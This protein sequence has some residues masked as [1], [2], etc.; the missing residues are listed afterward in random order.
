MECFPEH[1]HQLLTNR[2]FLFLDEVLGAVTRDRR[3][4]VVD[5]RGLA[6]ATYEP[7]AQRLVY[8]QPRRLVVNDARAAGVDLVEI[9]A[10]DADV[11]VVCTRNHMLYARCTA[12]ANANATKTPF[13]KVAASELLRG[14]TRAG[15]A[16]DAVHF[17][18]R[19]ANG[20]GQATDNEALNDNVDVGDDEDE[21]KWMRA[22]NTP[23]VAFEAIESLRLQPTQVGCCAPPAAAH[24]H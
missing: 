6:V 7:S 22:L 1:D 4:R 21:T 18:A 15:V 3:G 2:G 24:M 9:S 16:V 10:R 12:S 11:S 14:K 17:L 23:S 5:W 8:A 19:A 20:I 13:A